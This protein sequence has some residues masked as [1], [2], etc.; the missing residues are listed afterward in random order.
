MADPDVPSSADG[1]LARDATSA[2]R[3]WEVSVPRAD[4]SSRIAGVDDAVAFGDA[5]YRIPQ[6]R[7]SCAAVSAWCRRTILDIERGVSSD[8]SL[9]G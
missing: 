2:L 3:G 1:Y 6:R 8:G 7:S 9:L 5:D 4:R